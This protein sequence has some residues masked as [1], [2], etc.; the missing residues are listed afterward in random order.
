MQL[1]LA[2]RALE[3][4]QQAVIEER[5]MIDAI[6]IADQCIGKAGEIDEP[7]PIGVIASE[8]LHLEP[9][10]KTDACE[11]HFGGETGKARSRDRAGT[12]KAEILVNDNDSILRPA[13]LTCLGRKRILT[14]VDSRLFSTWA[15]LDWRK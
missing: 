5:R 8:P 14:L 11:R 13:K 7:V 12:G 4:E 15:A 6:G 10:H 9:E 1:G 2:H 3:T